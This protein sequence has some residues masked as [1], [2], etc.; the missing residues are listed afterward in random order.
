MSYD[1]VREDTAP[2]IIE[3]L[4]SKVKRQVESRNKKFRLFTVKE[5][6]KEAVAQFNASA[7]EKYLE[8]AQVEEKSQTVEYFIVAVVFYNEFK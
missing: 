7:L 2:G 6:I 1:K 3:V 8:H 5:L 4:W